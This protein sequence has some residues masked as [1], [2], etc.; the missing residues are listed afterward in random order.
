[1]KKYGGNPYYIGVGD[2]RQENQVFFSGDISQVCMWDKCLSDD[3]IKE[4]YSTDYPRPIN[5]KLYYDFSVI[6]DGTIYDKSGNGNNGF[7]N[8]CEI[9]SE[10]LQKIPNTILPH[11]NRPGRFFSQHHE[12]ND[13]VG[14]KWVH[15]KDTSIN[16]LRFVNEVQGGIINTDEDGLSDLNYSVVKKEQLFGTRHEIIDFKCEQDIPIHVEF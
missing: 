9:S 12:R 10:E 13:M 6:T 16:E 11:R 7:L 8:G 4:F 1:L 15:Q 5:T 14:G 3:E 2:P